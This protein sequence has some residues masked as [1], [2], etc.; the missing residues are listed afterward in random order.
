MNRFEPPPSGILPAL[1]P[2]VPE[3]SVGL[4]QWLAAYPAALAGIV[5]ALGVACVGIAAAAADGALIGLHGVA[6]SANSQGEAQK[7]LDLY[8]NDC[9][10]DALAACPGVAGWASEELEDVAASPQHGATGEHLVI[11][12]PVD[13]SSNIEANI[14]FGTIFSILPRGLR[15]AMLGAADFLQPGRRQLAAGYVLY[16]PSTIMVLSCGAEVAMFTLH[17]ASGQ[18]LLTQARV[19]IPRSTREF[20]INASNHRH[21]DKPVQRYIAECAAG[22]TGPRRVDFNMRWVASLV[23]DVHRLMTRGG[24]YLYPRDARHP[25][26]LRL[27]YE[28]AP[29]AYLVRQAGGGAV[30]G[31]Q[32]LLDV[33]P[34]L[35][36]QRS[37][38]ILGSLDE[39]ERIVAYHADPNENVSMPLFRNRSL[40]VQPQA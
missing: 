19:E 32:D 30:T 1:A 20:A 14:S 15:G 11:F 6:G 27:M 33:V 4:D 8:A 39:V 12:D 34:D 24:I 10:I 23:A 21:W 13:G 37:P 25:G 7:K 16:G 3:V 17:R 22:E 40:F 26:R 29:M 35:V 9:I 36:H 2:G 5:R 18:W 38:V 28:A 31:T